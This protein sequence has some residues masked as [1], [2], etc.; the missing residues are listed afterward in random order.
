[1]SGLHDSWGDLLLGSRC[2]GCEQPGRVLCLRCRATLPTCAHP[3]WPSPVPLGMVVPF[4]SADYDGLPRAMV[5]GLKERR[6]LALARPLAGVLSIAVAAA[7][8]EATPAATVLVPVPSRAVSVRERGHDPTATITRGAASLMRAR[9]HDVLTLR[10]L[11]SRPGVVDQAGLDAEHRAANLGGS[12]ACASS[13]LRRLAARR[14]RVRVV[15]C[16]DILTTGATAREAQRA[17]EAVGLPVLA[18]ATVAAT[19]KRRG[20]PRT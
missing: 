15:V 16:D 20:G 10:L 12:M 18:I 7:I 6:I 14:D 2:V 19:R 11:R 5:L 4:A 8:E 13:G 3:A 9:G 1:M 17:L